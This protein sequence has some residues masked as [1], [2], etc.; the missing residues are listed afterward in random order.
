MPGRP[1]ASP[2]A[3]QRAA[4]AAV[5]DVLTGI[6]PAIGYVTVVE[7]HLLAALAHQELATSAPLLPLAR[8]RWPWRR[9]TGLS[10]RSR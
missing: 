7:A 1:S 3:T 9:P 10:S 6:A 5:H 4:L 8:A 2:K